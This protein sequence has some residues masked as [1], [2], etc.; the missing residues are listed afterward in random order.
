MKNLRK[1]R[2]INLRELARIQLGSNICRNY[3]S[4][5]EHVTPQK[6]LLGPR[7]DPEA[8][9]PETGVGELVGR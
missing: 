7:A 6:R 4:G 2:G 9:N 5:G 3:V 1:K 8:D